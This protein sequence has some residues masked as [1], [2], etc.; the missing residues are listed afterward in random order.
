MMN[1][2]QFPIPSRDLPVRLLGSYRALGVHL[3]ISARA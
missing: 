3:F 2:D 1:G